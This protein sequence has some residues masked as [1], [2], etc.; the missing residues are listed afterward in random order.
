MVVVVVVV[1][2]GWVDIGFVYYRWINLG[3]E[4]KFG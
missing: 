4:I 3:D 1:G 2:G